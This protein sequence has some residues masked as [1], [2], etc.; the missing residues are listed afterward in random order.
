MINNEQLVKDLTAKDEQKALLAA[1]E[2][3]NNKNIEAFKI[4]A[5]KTEFLFDFVKNNV[6]KRLSRAINEQNYRN[7]FEF[8][9]I[10]IPEYE[11]ALVGALANFANEDLTDEI[12]NLLENGYYIMLESMVNYSHWMVLL[13][14]YVVK[15]TKNLEEHKILF[16]DPYYD[17]LKL[18]NA[19][20]FIGMWIDGNYENTKV[21]NDFIVIFS[22]NSR[23][24]TNLINAELINKIT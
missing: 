17:D 6:A 7:I 23:M 24:P 14:Y 4:L 18:L 10:Y 9:T 13:G 12:L 5:N 20:E 19:D 11:D 3:I 16:Y 21:K 15:D 1:K 8:L 22:R 2:I